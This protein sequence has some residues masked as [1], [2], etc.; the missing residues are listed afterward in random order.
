MRSW[1]TSVQRWTEEFQKLLLDFRIDGYKTGLDPLRQAYDTSPPSVHVGEFAKAR[2]ALHTGSP[3]PLYA[4]DDSGHIHT[5]AHHPGGNLSHRPFGRIHGKRIAGH[6]S[7]AR[8]HAKPEQRHRNAT[9]RHEN[10]NPIHGSP[11]WHHG[12]ANRHHFHPFGHHSM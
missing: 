12:N 5:A 6:C 11:N 1:R 4:T 7:P 2:P 9:G 3:V 10:P 8:C